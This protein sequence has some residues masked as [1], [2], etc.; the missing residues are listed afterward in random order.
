MSLPFLF[1]PSLR[2]VAVAI[3]MTGHGVRLHRDIPYFTSLH[4]YEVRAAGD[5]L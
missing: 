4:H 2:P 3:R 5:R 1:A